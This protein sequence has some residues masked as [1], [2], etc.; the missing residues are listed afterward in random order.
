MC[1]RDS[2]YIQS[3]SLNG[4]DHKYSYITHKEILKG[5]ELEFTMGPKPNKDFGKEKKY[6]PE[7]I[8]Y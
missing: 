3:V 8:V 7:S 5:G 6:R 4:E 2:I 1:I